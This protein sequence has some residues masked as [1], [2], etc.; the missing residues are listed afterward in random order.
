M[1][2]VQKY[3]N[4]ESNNPE[5]SAKK[6]VIVKILDISWLFKEGNTFASLVAFLAVSER[7]AIFESKLV[8]YLL[9][10]FWKTEQNKIIMYLMIPYF[11]YMIIAQWFIILISTY[12]DE[13][14]EG[15]ERAGVIILASS[16]LLLWSNQY[17]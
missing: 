13:P 8:N 2:D 10:E 1:E 16:T 12:G 7:N 17:R 14:K 9:N 4:A 15:M 5:N 3:I 6:V 11:I